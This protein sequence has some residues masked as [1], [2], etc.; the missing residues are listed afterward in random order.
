MKTSDAA[1]SFLSGALDAAW[2]IAFSLSVALFIAEHN[3]STAGGL[4][5][6][7]LGMLQKESK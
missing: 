4:F 3:Y 5:C 1:L 7:Y 6:V 2:K